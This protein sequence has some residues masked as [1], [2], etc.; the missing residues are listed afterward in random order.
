MAKRRQIADPK[1]RK[2]SIRDK[3]FVVIDGK[4]VYLPGRYKSAESNQAYR[5]EIAALRKSRSNAKASRK[6]RGPPSP[7]AGPTL[8]GLCLKYLDYAADYYGG[9]LRSEYGNMRYAVKLLCGCFTDDPLASAFSALRLQHFQQWLVAAGHSR[10]Y[11]NQTL[12]KVKRLFKWGYAQEIVPE[13]VYHSTNVTAPLKKGRTKAPEKKKK[14]GVTKLQFRSVLPHVSETVKTMMVFQWYTGA[15]SGSICTAKPEQFTVEKKSKMMFWRPRHKSEWRE[16]DLTLPIGPR[17]RRA[18]QP[19]IDAA[20]PDEY[21]FRPEVA[22]KNKR[23]NKRYSSQTY[24]RAIDRAIERVNNGLRGEGK[25]EI[26]RWSPHQ[27]RHAKGQQVREK[28]GIEAAQAVLGHESLDATEIYS[29][30]RL[31]LAAKVARETG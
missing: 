23:F 16:V 18:I 30:R 25:I 17:C 10:A 6:K 8:A 13:S 24:Y 26:A 29:S 22:S 12:S 19:F 27:I 31:K 2:H 1:Y 14:V 15:R 11:V 9:S 21:L 20:K 4:R 5:A 28:Y 7:P 3:A